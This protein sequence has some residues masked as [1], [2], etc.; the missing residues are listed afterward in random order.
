MHGLTHFLQ[1]IVGNI[2]HIG[3]GID[4]HQSQTTLHPGGRFSN[5]NIIYIVSH[6]ARAQVGSVHG[7]G[8]AFLSNRSL[9]VIQSGSLQLFAQ[10]GSH[11]AG[12]TENALAVSTVCINGNIKHP[13]IQAQ[14]RFHIGTD[15]GVLG[16]YQQ[17]VVTGTGIQILSQTQFNAGAQHTMGF[18]ATQLTLFDLHN[19]F[20]GLMI[21]GSSIYRSTHQSYREFAAGANI[22]GTAADLQAFTLT[23]V[24]LTNMQVSLRNGFAFFHQTNNNTANIFT[25]LPGFFHFESTV[26]QSFF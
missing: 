2:N 5:L 4:T 19:T 9:G 10:S 1:Y 24:Y 7:N 22:I 11:F 20:N 16:Q 8:E 6:V 17:A 13:I 26:E 23:Y 12:H 18:I 21:F 15:L 25:D 3:D 14:Q